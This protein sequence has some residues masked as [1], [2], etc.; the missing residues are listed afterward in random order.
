V[1]LVAK[2]R[3]AAMVHE[4]G[5][6]PRLL[7]A[8]SPA[9]EAARAMVA[10]V[11]DPALRW[12]DLDDEPYQQGI[13]GLVACGAITQE[14]AEYVEALYS[15]PVPWVHVASVPDAPGT[16]LL[17]FERNGERRSIVAHTSDPDA[18]AQRMIGAL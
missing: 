11:F 16:Y 14:E 10:T 15:A 3:F 1:R 9:D 5:M 13:A 6:L 17:V 12:F 2:E 4:R 8:P 7:A 18:A